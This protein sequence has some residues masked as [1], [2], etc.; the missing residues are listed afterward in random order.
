MQG[1]IS[2]SRGATVNL[3]NYESLRIDITHEC[4][5]EY[6]AADE[7]ERIDWE[8]DI[9]EW[10]KEFLRREITNAQEAGG[11]PP[12]SVERFTG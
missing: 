12:Q 6:D 8:K 3:G 4:E 1:K 5:I 11:L 10:C 9:S 7:D 2:V